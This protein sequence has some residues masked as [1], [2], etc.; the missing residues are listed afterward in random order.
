M[1]TKLAYFVW[2]Y[3]LKQ[4]G[5]QF[6]LSDFTLT[7]LIALDLID[8]IIKEMEIKEIEEKSKKWRM[9]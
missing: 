3:R 8:R 5:F 6:N 2:L 1:Q 7:E 9:K 4:L